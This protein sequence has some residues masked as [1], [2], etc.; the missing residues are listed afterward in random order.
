MRTKQ[1][2][3]LAVLLIGALSAVFAA[4]LRAEAPYKAIRFK[5][6]VTPPVGLDMAYCPN[7]KVDMPIYVGGVILDDGATRVVWCT[8]DYIYVCGQTYEQWQRKIADAA[9][10]PPENVFLHSVHQ[11]DSMRVAPEFNPPDGAVD[12]NGKPFP[13]EGS[14]PGY[15]AKSIADI[16]AEIARLIGNDAWVPIA[17]LKTAETRV[18]GLASNRRLVDESGKGVTMR[19]TMTTDPALQA[20]PTGVIDPMLRTV[21]LVK[22]DGTIYAALHFYATH[23]QSAYRRGMVSGDVPGWAIRY[24]CE[25]TPDTLHFYFNGC[26]GNI[27]MGKYNPSADA[28]AIVALGTRLGNYLLKNLDRLEDRASGP[29]RLFR[30]EIDVPLDPQR[31]NPEHQTWGNRAYFEKTFDHWKRSSI[32]RFNAGEVNILSFGLS[33]LCIEYQLYAQELVPENFLATAAYGNGIYWYM[34]VAKA[35]EEGGYESNVEACLVTPEIEPVLKAG[36]R[37]ALAEL[38]AHPGWTG[39]PQK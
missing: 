30:V 22:E 27:T 18:G 21:A 1:P 13:L 29:I 8:C 34:P 37:E 28:A 3:L 32:T 12:D 35:F 31:A 17:S 19:W 36:I 5:V 16:T 24:A 15:V 38:I 25:K 7:N 39:A 6:D 11:H 23:P 14:D 20:W 9:G 33:E 2:L 10:C 4:G 26:G